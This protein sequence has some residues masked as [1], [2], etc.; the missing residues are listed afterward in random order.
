MTFEEVVL[1][2]I[3]NREE[4]KRRTNIWKERYDSNNQ[5]IGISNIELC[6][7]IKPDTPEYSMVVNQMGDIYLVKSTLFPDLPIRII[8]ASN[9]K[10]YGITY[11]EYEEISGIYEFNSNVQNGLM[12]YKSFDYLDKGYISG[13]VYN[14]CLYPDLDM[15]LLNPIIIIKINNQEKY[16]EFITFTNEF[17]QMYISSKPFYYIPIYETASY[18]VFHTIHA[19]YNKN[20]GIFEYIGDNLE[21]IKDNGKIKD[22]YCLDEKEIS[23]FRFPEFFND[24]ANMLIYSKKTSICLNKAVIDAQYDIPQ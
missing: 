11:I 1:Y 22:E 8:F 21:L 18:N 13:F 24:S 5:I 4:C 6:E 12:I 17:R 10:R 15:Y 20:V 14:E 9:D 23:D 16:N 2:L 7:F 3:N 19:V